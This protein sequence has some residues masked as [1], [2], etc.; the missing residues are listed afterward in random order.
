[1][2]LD[3]GAG[4]FKPARNSYVPTG[5]IISSRQVAGLCSAP[6]VFLYESMTV[7]TTARQPSWMTLMAKSS[8]LHME[9]SSAQQLSILWPY[10]KDNFLSQ[11]KSIWFIVAYLAVFQVLVLGL[12]ITYTTMISAGMFVVIVGLMFFMEGLR[13][14]LMPERNRASQT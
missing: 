10:I 4:Q 13:L 14:G 11:L 12:P 6:V 7:M 5:Q 2:E 9:L 3:C 1:M 8:A